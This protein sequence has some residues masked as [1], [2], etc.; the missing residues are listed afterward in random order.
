MYRVPKWRTEFYE[1][2]VWLREYNWQS[3]YIVYDATSAMPFEVGNEPWNQFGILYGSGYIDAL[4]YMY[5]PSQR[6]ERFTLAYYLPW[7]SERK[8]DATAVRM[9]YNYNPHQLRKNKVIRGTLPD[10]YELRFK[11]IDE[12]DFPVARILSTDLLSE[13]VSGLNHKTIANVLMHDGSA[14]G[15]RIGGIL[16]AL[17]FGHQ[18]GVAAGQRYQIDVVE[19][20]AFLA[21]SMKVEDNNVLK[22]P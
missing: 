22:H 16:R 12:L 10:W 17:P 1:S 8:I 5:C 18:S 21:S 14:R 4:A 2:G 15:V 3:R 13:D 6:D 20:L 7:P 19:K 9:A 11:R